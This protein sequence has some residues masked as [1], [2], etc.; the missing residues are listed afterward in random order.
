MPTRL[1]AQGV[2]MCEMATFGI[3]VL[4]S[5]IDICQELSQ[6]FKNM[7]MFNIG[8]KCNLYDKLKDAE[9]MYLI[10]KNDL[11]FSTN[12]VGKEVSIIEGCI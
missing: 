7:I 12:T 6:V 1:D 11:L 5:D 10:G 2:M 3:P 9:R 4:T 8:E